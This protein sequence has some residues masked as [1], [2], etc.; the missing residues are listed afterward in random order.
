M[1]S[2]LL[3]KELNHIADELNEP[4]PEELKKLFKKSLI[5]FNTVMLPLNDIK[6]YFVEAGKQDL[7]I[8]IDE[9]L[10]VIVNVFN[11][12]GREIIPEVY[13]GFE[14]LNK[15]ARK[16]QISHMKRN[17]PELK[18]YVYDWAFN[19]PSWRMQGKQSTDPFWRQFFDK[20]AT[21]VWDKTKGNVEVVYPEGL[22]EA[23]EDYQRYLSK[24][25][26]VNVSMEELPQTKKCVHMWAGINYSVPYNAEWV[27][28]E[29]LPGRTLRC[30]LCGKYKK[31]NVHAE[32]TP[33]I[34]KG[35]RMNVREISKRLGK[36]ATELKTA[37]VG[38]KESRI[39]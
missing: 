20:F 7:A 29:R 27:G 39:R 32:K 15:K 16:K 34:E 2:K 19:K 38:D 18:Q 14:K 35:A 6:N 24:G 26:R 28:D 1:N 36:I 37:E 17:I 23:W 13:G 30:M 5:A 4:Y 22:D 25:A 9:A 8:E 21:Y 3:A 31:N 12:L 10:G 11:L 33:A